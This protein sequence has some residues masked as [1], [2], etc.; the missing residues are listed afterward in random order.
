LAV[1]DFPGTSVHTF[2]VGGS[3]VSCLH[4]VH[5]FGCAVATGGVGSIQSS[6]FDSSPTHRWKP[7]FLG[8]GPRAGLEVETTPGFAIQVYGEALL[9]LHWLSGLLEHVKSPVPA[10]AFPVSG[11]V[12]AS[13]RIY[14]GGPR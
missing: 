1:E 4:G 14:L 2:F 10:L 8:T 9:A 11:V 12:G 7:G 13:L 6:G 5:L 3:L